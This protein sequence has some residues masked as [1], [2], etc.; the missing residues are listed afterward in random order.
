MKFDLKPDEYIF[1]PGVDTTGLILELSRQGKQPVCSKC[2]KRLIYALTP[3]QA[4]EK[5]VPPGVYC[6]ES[7]EHCQ[8]VVSFGDQKRLP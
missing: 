8:I 3:I 7:L 5:R 6:P 1:R 2:G 4:R